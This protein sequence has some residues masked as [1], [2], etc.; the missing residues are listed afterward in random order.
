MTGN[1]LV[2]MIDLETY[3]LLDEESDNILY[4]NNAI[5][6]L[7][8]FLIGL[9]D[10]DMIVI[11]DISD[12]EAVSPNFVDFVPKNGYPLYINGDKYHII[13]DDM[14]IYDVKYNVSK[15]HVTSLSDTVPFRDM[16]AGTLVLIAS[17]LIKKHSYI[18]PAYCQQDEA[19][20]QQL[21][22]S[23]KAAKGVA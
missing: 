21:M 15:P 23:I 19:F 6:L 8:F 11:A 22:S 5:E 14:T 9:Q 3:G 13:S 18:T 7:S 16:Y 2:S 17:Y 12:G 20:V 10:P 1:D 4:I